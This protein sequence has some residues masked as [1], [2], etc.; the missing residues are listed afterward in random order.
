M[1]SY[2]KSLEDTLELL[3]KDQKHHTNSLNDSLSEDEIRKELKQPVNRV[4]YERVCDRV[5]Q[6]EDLLREVLSVARQT[7]PEEEDERELDGIRQEV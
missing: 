3:E 5:T 4:E 1:E 6:L 7:P 2:I